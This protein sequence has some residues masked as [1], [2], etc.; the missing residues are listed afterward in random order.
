MRLQRYLAQAGIASRRAAE[1]L[2]LA[3][4]VRVDG[5]PVRVLGTQVAPG[6]RV[7]FEGRVVVPPMA[8]RYLLLHKPFG[9]VTTMRDP[10]GRPTV[11]GL[12]P[13]G[14]GR[15][16]PV[17]RL[18]YDTAGLLLLTDDGELAHRLSHPRYG[19]EKSYRAVVRGRLAAE[20]VAALL[21]GIP[22][23]DGPAHPAKVRVVRCGA[24]HSELDLT[25]HEGRNRQ[26]RRMLESAG[27][28]VLSLVRLR[29]GPLSLGALE[30]GA[31]RPATAAEIAALRQAAG[32]S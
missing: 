19:V 9:V 20:A 32:L 31:H 22:L 27:H 2:I 16:V 25:I 17:G 4:R 3:G 21:A 28:P 1:E 14:A 8:W 7:E 6:A 13:A 11:A 30:A 12:I 26:V 29:F 18:D 10:A 15:V 24:Q 23:A 5:E